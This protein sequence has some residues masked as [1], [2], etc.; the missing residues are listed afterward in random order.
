MGS[1]SQGSQGDQMSKWGRVALAAICAIMV[2]LLATDQRPDDTS[3]RTSLVVILLGVSAGIDLLLFRHQRSAYSRTDGMVL[4]LFMA[5]FLLVCSASALWAVEPQ[6]TLEITGLAWLLFLCWLTVRLWADRQS[7]KRVTMVTRW[8]CVAILAFAVLLCSEVLT[9]Q[10]IHRYLVND[11]GMSMS[12]PNYYDTAGDRIRVLLQFLS[13][14]MATLSYLFWP[15]LLAIVLT[16][17]KS[18]FIFMFAFSVLTAYA[19]WNSDN[20]TAMLSLCLGAALFALAWQLPRLA[21]GVAAVTW[22]AATIAI[23]PLTYVVHDVLQLQLNPHIPAS[24]QARF[25]IWY[26]VASRV[27]EQPYIGH[28]VVSLQALVL[29]GN[30]F[31]GEHAH[32]HNVFLQTWYETG[33]LGSLLLL[34]CALVL[35]VRLYH[36]PRR[37]VCYGVATLAT[38]SISFVTTAWELWVPWHLGAV[39][40]AGSLF[41]LTDRIILQK[42][43]LT[44]E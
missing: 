43:E 9:D 10:Y 18:R 27:G 2:L 20:Q 34:A 6:R 21:I 1:A 42:T 5:G 25:P 12:I 31:L 40:L 36:Y 8:I 13:Q 38:V 44:V 23:V 32:A 33:I 3:I 35:L 15:T 7:V 16:F 19:V 41:L 14:H 24:G 39:A 28:G 30:G 4:P 37:F 22:I 26:E 11:I 17:G 29:S